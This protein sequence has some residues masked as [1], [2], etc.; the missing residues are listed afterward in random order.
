MATQVLI[1]GNHLGDLAALGLVHWT[2]VGGVQWFLEQL[3]VTGNLPW[4]VAIVGLSVAVRVA[5]GPLQLRMLVNNSKLAYASPEIQ[6]LTDALKEAGSS[7]NQLAMAKVQKQ[8]MDVYAKHDCHPLKSLLSPVV[9]LPIGISMFIAIRKMC[10]VPVESMKTGGFGW[11][12]DLTAADPLYILPVVSSLSM[13]AMIRVSGS[14]AHPIF[15]DC[16]SPSSF[17]CQLQTP[18]KPLH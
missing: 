10:V 17:R 13:L 14:L 7:R 9:Q 1:D 12:T 8:M 15:L 4:W 3:H 2:P 16:S 11:V 18:P 6:P 5:L